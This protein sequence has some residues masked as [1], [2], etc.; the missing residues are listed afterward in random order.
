MK[1]TRNKS[2]KYKRVNEPLPLIR[3]A[4]V[5][6]DARGRRKNVI[7]PYK[8]YEELIRLVEDVKDHKLMDEVAH[9]TDIPWEVA[10]RKL[11]K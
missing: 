2:T 4:E 8:T 9:E 3:E 5:T 11:K 1:L 6:Y 10:K 7:L